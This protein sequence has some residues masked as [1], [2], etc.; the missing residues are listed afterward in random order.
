M[1]H[2]GGADV[3]EK[4]TIALPKGRIMEEAL[5]MLRVS[6][7][8]LPQS[9]EMSRKL[10]IEDEAS[11]MN[12]ILAKPSDVPIYVEYG[13]ADLG[14]AGKDVLL[15]ED[16]DVYE[17]LDLKIAACRLC[18]A[19]KANTVARMIPRVATKF[20][21]VA[22][23]YYRKQGK[24]VEIIK[25]NG[26]IEIA[27]LIGLADCIVDIV[28]TGQTL[29]DNGLVELEEIMPITSRLIANRMSY[30]MKHDTIVDLVK[31]I[32]KHNSL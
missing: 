12:F 2:G 32:Q 11:G 4:L 25:L 26:S 1:E 30:R 5:E 6:G 17:L 3:P 14:V 21:R 15:E 31:K 13:A 16:R 23:D 22:S 10:I 27:P 18:V 29:K 7:F 19:G 20:S 9:D 8:D 24:Q 28:S